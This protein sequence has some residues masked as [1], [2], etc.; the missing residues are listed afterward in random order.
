MR[1][2]MAKVEEPASPV[3]VPFFLLANSDLKSQHF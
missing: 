1:C 2:L 3:R